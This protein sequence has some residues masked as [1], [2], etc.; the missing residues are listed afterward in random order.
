MNIKERFCFN[1]Q[2]VVFYSLLARIYLPLVAI[3]AFVWKH[4]L[5][6]RVSGDK[7]NWRIY[8]LLASIIEDFNL[9][10]GELIFR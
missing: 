9:A 7:L 1:F 4:G 6:I 2:F 8:L 5:Q 3:L 10:F